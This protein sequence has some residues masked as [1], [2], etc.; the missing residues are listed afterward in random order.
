METMLK[1]E[2]AEVRREVL[3][4]VAQQLGEEPLSLFHYV[5]MS[6]DALHGPLL[7]SFAFAGILVSAIWHNLCNAHN[8]APG[9]AR[10]QEDSGD[11][12]EI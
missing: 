2:D 4:V 8:F 7:P 11:C 6:P 12:I 10:P 3:S 9:D 1:E 5:D